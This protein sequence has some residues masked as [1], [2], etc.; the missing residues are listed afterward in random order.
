MEGADYG[1]MEILY[2]VRSG[3]FNLNQ[4]GNSGRDLDV[5]TKQVEYELCEGGG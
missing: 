3:P 1:D 4:G 2:R 5:V